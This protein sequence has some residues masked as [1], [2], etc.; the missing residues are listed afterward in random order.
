[1]KAVVFDLDNTL[2]DHTASSTAAIHEWVAELGGTASDELVAQWFV[3]EERNFNQW[4]SGAVT[5]QGQRRGRLRDFL[6]LLGRPVPALDEELDQIYTGYL[7][8]YQASWAAYPDARLALEVARS[9]GWRVGVLTNGSTKQQNA[10]LA[11][12]G[13]A[14]LVDVVCTSESLGVSKPDPQAYLQTCGALGVEPA[15][16]VMIGDNLELDVL[17]ARQAGLTAHHLDRAAGLTLTE[18]LPRS[19]S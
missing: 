6:P 1:M 3:I 13:L 12:I 19:R 14:D 10:K 17:A 16:T 11:A 8:H 5:H 7:R 18:I 2:F 15:D 4:L 9:N